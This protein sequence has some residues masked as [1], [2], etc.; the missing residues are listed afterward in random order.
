MA[1]KVLERSGLVPE[2][3][4]EDPTLRNLKELKK[5]F[6]DLDV[7]KINGLIKEIKTNG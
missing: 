4:P 1:K 2:R 7:A 5:D 6:P 3:Q